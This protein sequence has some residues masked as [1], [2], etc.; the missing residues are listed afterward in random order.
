MISSNLTPFSSLR[1]RHVLATGLLAFFVLVGIVLSYKIVLQSS[2]TAKQIISDRNEVLRSSRLVRESLLPINN[3]MSAFLLEPG[4][5]KLL[6]ELNFSLSEAKQHAINLSLQAARLNLTK[7][8]E[9]KGLSLHIEALS[10]A[11]NHMVNTRTD[12]VKQFPSLGVGNEKMRPN[13]ND[14]NNAMALA[15]EESSQ[16]LNPENSK[17]YENLLKARHYWTQMVSNFRLYIANRLGSFD[18]TS[19]P[20]QEQ[21]IELLQVVLQEKLQ[22]LSQFDNQDL[23][24]FETTHALEQLITSSNLWY[25]GYEESKV[26]HKSGQWRI[27]K[28]FMQANIIPQLGEIWRLLQSFDKAVEQAAE[29]DIELANQKAIEQQRLLW[30]LGFCVAITVI[31]ILIYAEYLIYGPISKV[32]AALRDQAAGRETEVLPSVSSKETRDLV[33]AFFDMKMQVRNRQLAL[34]H[35]SLHD[36][37][38]GLPNRSLFFDRIEHAIAVADTRHNPISILMIELGN[39][40][41]INDTVGHNTGDL[42]ILEVSDRL[43]HSITESGSVAKIGGNEFAI[44]LTDVQHN[45]LSD[46]VENL[47][48][49]IK[50]PILYDEINVHP[51]V[52]IGISLYP[53]H[54]I[55]ANQLLQKADIAVLL[56]KQNHQEI[57]FYNE[58]DDHFSKSRLSLLSDLQK[59]VTDDQLEMHFQPKLN[60]EHQQ[61]FGVEA[62]L[63][64]KHSTQG[65]IQAAEIISI[66][67]QSGLIN[68][69]TRWTILVC[70]KQSSEW[71]KLG[72]TLNI[73]INLSVHTLQDESIV[74]YTQSILNEF[75]VRPGYITFELT[76]SA[77]M[78]NPTR[79][80]KV[81]N[82]LS[83]LGIRISADDFG[84]GFS[85]L[86]YLKHLP[87]DEI[88]IDRSFIMDMKANKTDLAIVKS[89]IT[90]AHNLEIA[91]VAEGIET[92]D[93]QDLLHK[94]K[95][96][97]GQGY[98][99]SRPLASSDFLNW[100]DALKTRSS[101]PVI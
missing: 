84:T 4:D 77:M 69:L 16:E 26:I 30:L 85:S 91:V 95:C 20:L 21:S 78:T 64:W 98:Y 36:N 38:T 40:K 97:M 72:L 8:D 31:V 34:E 73:A 55:N 54:G 13:R 53:E 51:V 11:T 27:D 63:R 59:A 49:V 46:F 96:D 94:L 9:M 18:L 58:S 22:E 75:E 57:S 15:V 37:L 5:N 80:F 76:E 100:L 14:F 101:S 88:K 28:I 71:R 25:E 48:E 62:L 99:Y 43:M 33:D 70:A 6:T 2:A 89:A 24:G 56:A 82:R 81:L 66:A 3:S 39:L 1:S 10:V 93:A 50:C 90:L 67:E 92:T 7:A 86:S 41:E 45:E 44:L 32:A 79:V 42:L 17:V 12:P 87:I 60:L 35:N 74:E 29:Q 23:L 52:N 68:S 83:G 19:L 61:V 65:W 47:V